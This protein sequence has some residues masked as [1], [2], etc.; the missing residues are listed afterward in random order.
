MNVLIIYYACLYTIAMRGILE[1]ED[2]KMQIDTAQTPIFLI[3][4]TYSVS[5]S[6][7][8]C[9]EYR[10]SWIN[11]RGLQIFNKISNIT[12]KVKFERQNRYLIYYNG[13]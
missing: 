4:C 10:Y 12:L 11:G 7:S 13:G 3:F 5:D 6:P 9:A 2:S 1:Q 8:S